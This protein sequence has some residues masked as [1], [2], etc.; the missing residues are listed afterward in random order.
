MCYIY[1]YL[2]TRKKG[3]YSYGDLHFEYE[4]FLVGEN[5]DCEKKIIFF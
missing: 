5:T 4:P 1:V 2:D 3:S